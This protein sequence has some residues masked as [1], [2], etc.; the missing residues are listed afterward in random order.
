MTQPGYFE[1]F[2][3]Q[4]EAI[5]HCREVNRGLASTAALLHIAKIC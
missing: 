2:E 3:T 1:F 4:D 5:A